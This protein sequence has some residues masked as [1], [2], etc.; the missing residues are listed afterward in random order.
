VPQIRWRRSGFALIA[1]IMAAA[2]T[3]ALAAP[4]HAVYVFQEGFSMDRFC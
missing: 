4:K 1:D 2:F 3:T